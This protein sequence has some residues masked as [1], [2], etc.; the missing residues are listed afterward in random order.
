M[1]EMNSLDPIVKLQSDIQA[2]Q[3]K[4]NDLQTEVRLN[5]LR[6]EMED[7]ETKTALLVSRVGAIR[8]NGYVFQ[9]DLE[10]RA[11]DLRNEWSAISP[12][13]VE[14]VNIQANLLDIDARAIE[15][16][17]QQLT[18]R[19]TNVAGATP[20][21]SQVNA[22]TS[23]L[24]SKISSI[25]T[26]IK[27]MYDKLSGEISKFIDELTHLEW[28]MEQF[29]GATFKLLNTEAA[30]NAVKVVWETTGKENKNDP[31]G[32]LYLTD[33]RLL[34][35]QNQEVATKKILF[36]ATEK[37]KIQKLMFEFPVILV[38]NMKTA[39]EGFFK[40]EDHL[41]L[42][43]ATGGP[44]PM[45]HFHLDGQ[46]CESWM[47]QINKVKAK[48][49]DIDRTVPIQAEELEK[50]KNAPTQCPRCGVVISKPILRGMDT[51]TCDYCGN[52]IRI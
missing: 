40:N 3:M 27:G 33:Q 17:M 11:A 23:S 9:K 10:N 34:F 41:D 47:N 46:D 38:V 48:E 18:A 8:T 28:M 31:K 20:F 45:V 7:I 49:Y 44:F 21:L 52:V 1:A 25:Q 35:E 2:A 39:K 30:V 43:L 50:V 51:I 6:D 37:E 26:T 16:V 32:L 5:S 14:Q 15:I 4:I 13:I 19:S 24:E 42:E 22:G 36:I 29:T 12:K